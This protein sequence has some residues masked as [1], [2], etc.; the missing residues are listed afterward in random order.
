M[1]APRVGLLAK[2]VAGAFVIAGL[3]SV[4]LIYEE[5]RQ[6]TLLAYTAIRTLS[7]PTKAPEEQ[8]ESARRDASV[9]AGAAAASVSLGIFG[10][11]AAAT[12]LA[13]AGIAGAVRAG[14]EGGLYAMVFVSVVCATA[15]HPGHVSGLFIGHAIW[16][17]VALRPASWTEK[18]RVRAW[19]Q[20]RTAAALSQEA[21]PN[22]AVTLQRPSE[23][24]G[25]SASNLGARLGP[26]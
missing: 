24:D 22:D 23:G 21:K 13:S 26:G 4:P 2:L 15:T 6:E 14:V 18:R 8:R 17:Y 11:L 10:V 12:L 16:T 3:A 1:R 5:E 7:E 19:E 20:W 9:H 25:V